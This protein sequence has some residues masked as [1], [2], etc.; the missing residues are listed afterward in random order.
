MI[1]TSLV[2]ANA[3]ETLRVDTLKSSDA[4]FLNSP[5]DSSGEQ[6]DTVHKMIHGI[7]S[8]QPTATFNVMCQELNSLVA[9]SIGQQFKD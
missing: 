7:V 4:V 3:K 2:D 1:S 9:S 5:N 8:S 6:T